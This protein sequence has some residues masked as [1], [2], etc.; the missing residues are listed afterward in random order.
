MHM[1][2]IMHALGAMLVLGCGGLCP[3]Y[4]WEGGLCDILS[5]HDVQ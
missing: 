2:G 3:P 1:W 4:I 5:V